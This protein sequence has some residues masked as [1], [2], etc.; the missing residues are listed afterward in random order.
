[1]NIFILFISLLYLPLYASEFDDLRVEFRF[2]ELPHANK[3]S[4]IVINDIV[5]DNKGM[6]WIAT[7]DGLN[8]YD[9]IANKIYRPTEK[10]T[11]AISHFFISTL[12]V[13]NQGI[14]WV[15]TEKGL[16]QYDVEID[17]FKT[18][19]DQKN[20]NLSL[21]QIAVS[22][23]Y[24]DS[25]HRLWIG[26]REKGVYLISKDRKSIATISINNVTDHDFFTQDIIEFDNRI[27]VASRHG[28]YEFN[29]ELLEI[30]KITASLPNRSKNRPIKETTM[31]KLSEEIL[32]VGTRKG[33]FK[34]DSNS[35]TFTKWY[36]DVFDGHYITKLFLTN[37]KQLL[38]G[39]RYSGLITFNVNTLTSR[40]YTNI[41]SDQF[42]IIDNQ[43][44][45]IYQSN[46][47]LIWLGTN[48]GINIVNLNEKHFGHII[49]KDESSS[50]LSGNTIYAMLKDSDGYVWI[51]S[52]GHGLHKINIQ[53]DHCEILRTIP[54]YEN[55]DILANVVS[56]HEDKDKNL[57]IST[58]DNGLIK[59]S[60]Q[61][62]KFSVYNSKTEAPQTLLSDTV[63]AVSSDANG[64]IWV[65]TY[66]AGLAKIS[67]ENHSVSTI[68]AQFESD[69]GAYIKTINHI[70]ADKKGTLWL[71]TQYN[72][73]VK[74]N[75]DND[76]FT[77]YLRTESNKNGLPP[78]LLSIDE[79][80]DG[81]LWIGTRGYGAIA[82]DPITES[83]TVYA[84]ENGLSSNVVMGVK[85]DAIGNQWIYTDHGL[86][87]LNSSDQSIIT[88][89]K[90]DGMQSNSTTGA[91][92]YDSDNHS[93]WVAGINGFNIIS[94]DK[95]SNRPLKNPVLIT[96]LELFYK[97]VS[98][99][100]IDPLSPLKTS[101][102]TTNALTLKH[103]QNVFSLGYS[104]LA[105][106]NPDRVKY[107]FILE[108]YD[109]WNYVDSS[110]QRAVYTNIDPGQYTFKVKASNDGTWEKETTN[111]IIEIAPPW[112]QTPIAYFCY[113][114]AMAFSIYL[115]VVLRTQVLSRRAKQLEKSVII[116][117]KEL[118]EEK[119]KVEQL[120][121]RKNEELANISHEF[122]TPLTLIVGPLSQVMDSKLNHEQ[123][124]RLN[125]VQ[126]NGYRLL[127][128]VDQLLNIE[129]FRIKS[130][131]QKS[132]QAIGKTLQLLT[133][134]FKDLAEE[135]QL[136]LTTSEPI[137]VNFQFTPDA[138]EKIVVN[139]LSN[140]IKYTK[141]GGEIQINCKRTSKNE[142]RLCI[143]DTGIGI[144][145]T[146][147]NKVFERYSRVLNNDSESIAG[148]GIGL[149]LV[150]ELVKAHQGTISLISELDKGTTVIVTL[151]I[152]GEVK[153]E[154]VNP[155]I[156]N[157]IA[158]MEIMGLTQG[159]N[160]EQTLLQNNDTTIQQHTSLLLIED[161]QDMRNY[162]KENI[163]GRYKVFLAAN[164][165]D[166]VK[167][168]TQEVPDLIISDI[169]MPKLNGYEVTKKLRSQQS[170]DHIPIV[171]LT[172]RNDRES[173]LQGWQEKADEY[174][175]KPFDIEELLIRLEN[176]LEIR[177]I[178]KRRFSETVF[179]S[180]DQNELI[181]NSNNEDQFDI[182]DH[183]NQQQQIFITKLNDTLE[184]LYQDH[185]VSI[186]EIAKQ[187][188]MSDRQLQ[189]KLNSI[190][191]MKPVEY[192][193]RFRL[194][195]SVKL[196]EEGKSI[197]YTS[198]EVGFS[199]QSYFG[200]CFKA[201]FGLSPK[202]YFE[203]KSKQ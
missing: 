107:A 91:G 169:M 96:D 155:S 51:A 172:A 138:F 126:R 61:S 22:T 181:I 123:K 42:S 34:F 161:N 88:F 153:K 7:N 139:L 39:T 134:A 19:T 94:L 43:V 118:A 73:L 13:D 78:T 54:G 52:W 114:I 10:H 83:T 174:L 69:N 35:N 46:D 115:F 74:Y 121:S 127:R 14:L 168:A 119:T 143:S 120:L 32:L 195:K 23:I 202:A 167:I 90:E 59:Y 4:H 193:R 85:T 3:L 199:S 148:S 97:P 147:L 11:Q 89:F 112:W 63:N 105:F 152:I 113:V 79:T 98:L 146:Q 12:L 40:Q 102:T 173:R 183:V 182:Q 49:T 130:I 190:L 55:E 50:C 60:S 142:L 18:I 92:F 36:P 44:Y 21:D 87:R 150:K 186:V 76:K 135:K 178:L 103:D 80:P 158:A 197:F 38:V 104:A 166:G 100:N 8:R 65:A 192:L 151:P 200:V 125:V 106:E 203:L 93:L 187:M 48:L 17:S 162:I 110:I 141:A 191:D 58:F 5:Q 179:N 1:M 82:F 188:A 149:A 160:H 124:R 84:I 111:L 177:D 122:R 165:E 27:L 133:E 198:A 129:T 70:Y 77:R 25:H 185:T 95:I 75:I 201:Q 137:D 157:E 140:A 68:K 171:L 163:N 47:D 24:E 2:Q 154:Q 28:L 159:S 176:L 33:L 31:Y 26:T 128:M 56:L 196:I 116:R 144:P 9:G 164:G 20:P 194:E 64:N 62:Q 99:R 30:N 6:V 41:A 37:D 170:T 145:K 15:G 66:G 131:A 71:A 108:G 45:E 180:L 86:T 117:T 72:G 184:K 81:A 101:I 132:P 136:S 109:D 67:R 57:W 156:N 189:R 16:N 175:T 29:E 53:T